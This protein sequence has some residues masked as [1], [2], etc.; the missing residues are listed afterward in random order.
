[1]TWY[2]TCVGVMTVAA[3]TTGAAF[4]AVMWWSR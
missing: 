2:L 1:M 4:S 3:F